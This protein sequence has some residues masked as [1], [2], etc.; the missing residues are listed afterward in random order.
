[1]PDVNDVVYP[2]SFITEIKRLG[3]LSKDA[4]KLEA[5]IIKN[6][7]TFNPDAE[8]PEIEINRNILKKMKLISSKTKSSSG[9]FDK[10]KEERKVAK[11]L[12]R[13][14]Q[15][16]YHELMDHKIVIQLDN[17][18]IFEGNLCSGVEHL[19]D[20][21]SF[22]L[23]FHPKLKAFFLNLK[24]Y[25]TRLSF[26][27]IL[28]IE[29]SDYTYDLYKYLK[30][31]YDINEY[32]NKQKG[33][34]EETIEIE[35]ELEIIRNFLGIG[36]KYPRTPEFNRSVLKPAVK[37]I[38]EKTDLRVT[39]KGIRG[40]KN[41][42]NS[43]L[44]TV[45]KQEYQ[46]ELNLDLEVVDEFPNL[47]GTNNIPEEIVEVLN[48]LSFK[49]LGKSE[50]FILENLK[51]V[52]KEALLLALKQIDSDFKGQPDAVRGGV[53]K[54][55]LPEYV[56]KSLAKLDQQKKIDELALDKEKQAKYQEAWLRKMDFAYEEFQLVYPE[57]YSSF[58]QDLSD[59]V[60]GATV[61]EM[62]IKGELLDKGLL[63]VE[64]EYDYLK[65]LKSN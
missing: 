4:Q 27:V 23:S 49:L 52:G 58:V 21:E 13:D 61:P 6:I 32:K 20:G 63:E 14:L 1:M 36:N 24:E 41:L 3:T 47:I 40:S 53:V 9:S 15:K 18:N 64:K 26:Q 39:Y 12:K 30:S 45:S 10:K 51:G 11:N 59:K 50:K 37:E 57:Q 2:N 22:K 62:V 7:D 35:T 46:Q 25:F 38:S 56:L 65:K 17:G 16:T 44:F 48:N 5:Y 60:N 54:K 19:E 31:Q 55:L 28:K 29:D 42:I 34:D 8:W 33:I 43:Y